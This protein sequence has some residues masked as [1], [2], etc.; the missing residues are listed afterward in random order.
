MRWCG[1][2]LIIKSQTF[3]SLFIVSATC[4]MRWSFVCHQIS[5]ICLV[6]ADS[7]TWDGWNVIV[8]SSCESC[9]VVSVVHIRRCGPPGHSHWP[10]LRATCR[11]GDYTLI[12]SSISRWQSAPTTVS[13][14]SV[15]HH[16]TLISQVGSFEAMC[17][18]APLKG[19]ADVT[20]EG[21]WMHH[22]WQWTRKP[23]YVP[24]CYSTAHW[25]WSCA[26]PACFIGD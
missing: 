22:H 26:S 11:Q 23:L 21:L 12:M 3:H 1:V 14:L 2:Y 19:T 7:V 25:G 10:T 18:W 4:I 17:S 6:W 15:C 9:A 24:C 5:I 8:Q 13:L 16:Q 20:R